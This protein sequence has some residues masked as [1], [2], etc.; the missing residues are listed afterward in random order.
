MREVSIHC[1]A[2][3]PCT[4]IMTAACHVFLHLS[5]LGSV[6]IVTMMI[7][8][9]MAVVRSMLYCCQAYRYHSY[10]YCRANQCDLH[11]GV[12]MAIPIK[13]NQNQICRHVE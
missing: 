2:P 1:L 4:P 11:L 9:V 12:A 6:L 3:S 13:N 10:Q 5:P 7:Q 8:S